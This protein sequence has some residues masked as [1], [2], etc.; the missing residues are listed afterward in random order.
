MSLGPTE[1]GSRW[2]ELAGKRALVTGGT[3]NIGRGIASGLAREGV[4]VAVIGGADHQALDETLRE[5]AEHG[6][7][8]AGAVQPLEDAQGLADT[9]S[10]LSDELGHFDILINNAAIRPHAPLG[11]ISVK[12][13]DLVNAVNLRAPF[14]LAQMLLPGMKERGYGR[15]VNFSGMDAYWGRHS[16]AHVT[17]SKG[18]MVGLSRAL[19]SE[20]ARDGVTVNT[21]VP[22][23][24][25]VHRHTPQWYPNPEMRWQRRRERIPMG[26]LGEIDEVVAVALFLVSPRASY[27]TGHEFFVS[28]G[29]YPLTRE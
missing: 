9:V 13:W 25:D 14:L 26:R 8:V 28:G 10:Q 1:P 20:C 22:G 19:A 12:E 2:L 4:D 17:A 21:L 5:L 15:I 29:S 11:D 18:G 23:T 7:K 6:V 3:R 24:I 16:R 27:M